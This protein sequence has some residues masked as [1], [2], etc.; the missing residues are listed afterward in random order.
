MTK[1]AGIPAGFYVGAF[2]ISGDVGALSSITQTQ[3]LQD[4]TGLDKDGTE[5]LGLRQD[6]EMSYTAFWNA[7]VGRSVPVLSDLAA[8]QLST[9]VAN[10]EL[11]GYAAC[12]TANRV[13]FVTQLGQD[14]S[15][16]ANG[17]VQA[18]A[19]VKLEWGQL[20]TIGKQTFAATEAIAA[21]Q[22]NHAY[23]LNALVQP[24]APNGH[25][26]K[27][28]TGGT[29]AAVTEPTWP[30]NG[31]TVADG[32]DTL[33]WTDQGL[34]PNGIDRGS[35]SASAFGLAGAIHAVSIGSGSATVKIQTSTDR[36]A[37]TDLLTF[38]AVTAAGSEYK[39]TALDASVGRYLR[40][41]VTGT[42]TNLVATI[43]AIPY[44]T[45]Q[46]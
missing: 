13:N 5:R 31:T 10:S 23:S 35:G 44:R 7:A 9:F 39:R 37:W 28:T 14:G 32:A 22:A 19:G 20:V 38:A 45:Q 6:G 40:A 16:V 21:W 24:V 42:V 12:L 25:Y 29:S 4:V 17:Q 26:Y 11:G 46:A 8:G 15:I 30:T 27:A 43:V 3:A 1:R 36:V 18:S 41:N 33:V 2:D 34:L